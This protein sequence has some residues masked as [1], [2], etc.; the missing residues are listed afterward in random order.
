MTNK[1][2]AEKLAF[3]CRHGKWEDAQKA[4]YSQDAVSI[5][6][7]ASPVFDRETKGLDAIIA[8]GHKFNAMVEKLHSISVSEPLIAG[9]AIAFVIKMDAEMKG[10][11]RT[12]ME[13]IAV[14]QVKEGKIVSEQFHL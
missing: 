2:I 7:Q 11:G 10:R 3:Y 4:L 1:E 8:K 9:D 13:E 14:Y 5:E 12:T 6:L